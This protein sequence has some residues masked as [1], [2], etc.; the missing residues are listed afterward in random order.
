MSTRN[1][2]VIVEKHFLS[3]NSGNEIWRYP[4]LASIVQA[5]YG[6]IREDVENLKCPFCGMKFKKKYVVTRHINIKHRGELTYII[7]DVI[8][9][10]K[11]LKEGV[12]KVYTG[13]KYYVKM[14]INHLCIKSDSMGMLANYLIS[15]P[16]ILK[17]LNGEKN[18]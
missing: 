8:E 4:L 11:K 18:G 13:S 10:Y 15:H 14:C 5:L 1:I 12:R 9:M 2:E 7:Y 17:R 16:E 6:N 3:K